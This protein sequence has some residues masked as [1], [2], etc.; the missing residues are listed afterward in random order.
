M[1][2]TQAHTQTEKLDFKKIL[3]IFIIVLI[4]LLGLTIIIPLLS[5]YAATFGST[6][7]VIGLL[8]AAYPVAQFIGTP[9]LGR[10]SDRYG[11]KKI[12]LISQ[13]GTLIGFLVLAAS[14]S[15]WMLFLSRIIDGLSG[16]NISTAQAAIT[17]S[18]TP[19]TRTQGLGLIG[20]AFG[21]G[22]VFG[23]VIAFLSLLLSGNN[24]H[25]PALVAAGF[26][27]LSILATSFLFKETLP[28]EKRGVS[29]RDMVSFK[30]MIEALKRPLVGFLLVLMLM[31]QIAFGGFEQLLSL[32]SLNRLGLDGRGNSILFV[33]VGIL[34]VMVQGYFIG[35]WSKKYGEKWLIHTGLFVLAAGLLMTAL[36]PVLPVPWYSKAAVETSLSGGGRN[37][38][39]ETPPTQ[40]LQVPVPDDSHKGVLG[41]V[42]LLVAMVPAALGGGVLQPAIN[43]TITKSVEPHEIGGTLGV[44]AALLSGANAIAPV[45]GGALFQGVAP[46][47]PFALGAALLFGLGMWARKVLA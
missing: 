24:Y 22:F 40:T 2:A 16:A 29:S 44:S 8:G 32:F 30:A 47:F 42:W 10:L 33:F 13:I 46:W 34:V 45:V 15:I 20:A 12:L 17:D 21:I 39:G 43:S 6:P 19:K 11:R 3:P 31:Q 26:S 27:L 18:T 23:P 35:K 5:M 38:P 37:L 9:F 36:T 28:P 1:E 7:L 4:D 25:V 14:N 41:L